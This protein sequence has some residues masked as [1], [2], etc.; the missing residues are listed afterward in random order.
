MCSCMIGGASAGVRALSGERSMVDE[1]GIGRNVR[2][3]ASLS[4]SAYVTR[5]QWASHPQDAE[6]QHVPSN[7]HRCSIG[8]RGASQVAGSGAVGSGRR[9]ASNEQARY[10]KRRLV[11]AFRSRASLGATCL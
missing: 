8:R 9:S 1:T 3:R 7:A 4:L 11:R 10:G 5:C 2:R 6:F